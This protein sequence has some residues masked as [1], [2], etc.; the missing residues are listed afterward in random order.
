M[1]VFADLKSESADWCKLKIW[2]SAHLSRT[3]AHNAT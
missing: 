2:G 1:D 3:A